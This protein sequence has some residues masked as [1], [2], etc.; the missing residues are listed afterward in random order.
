MKFSDWLRQDEI[1]RQEGSTDTGQIA[2][3]ARPIG[4]PVDQRMYPDPIIMDDPN[5]KKRKKDKKD[6]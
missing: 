6:L 2:I 5:E 1:Q 4:C 3:F